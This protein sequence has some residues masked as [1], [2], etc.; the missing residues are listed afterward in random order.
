VFARHG[1]DGGRVEQIA[2][3]ARSYDRMIYYYFGSKEALFI[4]VIEDTYRRFNE[5]E[6]GWTLDTCAAAGRAA[7]HDPLHL[8]VLPEAT[9]SSSRCS[10]P[11]TCCAASTSPAAR[12]PASTR[13]RRW[14]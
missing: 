9:P 12:M 5:A 8:A 10:T 4:A 2:K 3:A 1:F 13:R 14:P 11:R 7:R 6:Q